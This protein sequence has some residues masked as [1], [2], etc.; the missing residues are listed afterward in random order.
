MKTD[1]IFSLVPSR[2]HQQDGENMDGVVTDKMQ[3]T[4]RGGKEGEEDLN[5]IF[6]KTILGNLSDQCG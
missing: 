6:L 3:A 2:K 1:H 4:V 5:R